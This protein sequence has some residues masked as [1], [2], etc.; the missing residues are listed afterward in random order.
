MTDRD[1][2]TEIEEWA[3]TE[4]PATESF[5]RE[6]AQAFAAIAT[7][8]AAIRAE[9]DF[10][11]SDRDL[12]VLQNESLGNALV[13]CQPVIERYGRVWAKDIEY[14]AAAEAL[15]IKEPPDPCEQAGRHV[16]GVVDSDLILGRCP[17]GVDL[18]LDI[19]PEG[20]RV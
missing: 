5:M 18:D 1:W 7:E 12:L 11:R 10:F 19:C 20:C 15:G 16:C 3:E 9:R 13:A 2:P 8:R 4:L 17:H 14:Y 6:V